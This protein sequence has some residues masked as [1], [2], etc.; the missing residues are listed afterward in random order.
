MQVAA[1]PSVSTSMAYTELSRMSFITNSP[2]PP[3]DKV[4]YITH[5]V[6]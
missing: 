5:K 1:D 6:V 4:V 2:L 3:D